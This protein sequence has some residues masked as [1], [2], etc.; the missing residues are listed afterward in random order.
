M[1]YEKTAARMLAEAGCSVYEIMSVT[2]HKSITEV[3]RYTREAS[4]KK[5]APAAL[6]KLEQNANGTES[7]KRA[8]DRSAKQK[9]RG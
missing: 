6:L 3:E 4:Q 1:A 7:A 8:P 2:G 5:L 9:P